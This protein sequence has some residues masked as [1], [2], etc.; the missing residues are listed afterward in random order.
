MKMF[1]KE[2]KLNPPSDANQNNPNNAKQSPLLKKVRQLLTCTLS[3]EIFHKPVYISCGHVFN[4]ISLE[5]ALSNK[6]AC[7]KC[8]KKNVWSTMKEDCNL[9]KISGLVS[10]NIDNETLITELSEYLQ[11]IVLMQLY[12]FPA[13]NKCGHTLEKARIPR[14]GNA[15]APDNVKECPNCRAKINQDSALPNYLMIALVGF[16]LNENPNLVKEQPGDTYLPSSSLLELYIH[17]YQAVI[18]QLALFPHAINKFFKVNGESSPMGVQQFIIK[19][20]QV[21]FLVE[22]LK[23]PLFNNGSEHYVSDGNNSSLLTLAAAES[24]NAMFDYILK[25]PHLDV[26]HKNIRGESALFIAAARGDLIKVKALLTKPQLDLVAKDKLGNTAQQVAR[27]AGHKEIAILLDPLAAQLRGLV[28]KPDFTNIIKILGAAKDNQQELENSINLLLNCLSAE[29]NE[30][31]VFLNKLFDEIVKAK[32]FDANT[33]D[34]IILII[35]KKNNSLVNKPFLPE[36]VPP[37]HYA[38][39]RNDQGLLVCRLIQLQNINVNIA[40]VCVKYNAEMTPLALAVAGNWT[41]H[42]LQILCD[43]GADPNKDMSNTI[44]RA[45]KRKNLEQ[46]KVLL[47]FVKG[48]A[49]YDAWECSKAYGNRDTTQIFE[50]PLVR[51]RIYIQCGNYQQAAQELFNTYVELPQVYEEFTQKILQFL[52]ANISR[53]ELAERLGRALIPLALKRNNKKLCIEYL[54]LAPKLVNEI[55]TEDGKTILHVIIAENDEATLEQLLKMEGLEINKPISN[56]VRF[57]HLSTAVHLACYQGVKV[58]ILEKLLVQH[59]TPHS[60]NAADETPL[61]IATENGDANKVVALLALPDTPDLQR[62]FDIA[63]QNSQDKE[64][65]A[66]FTSNTYKMRMYLQEKNYKKI[67]EL[68]MKNYLSNKQDVTL[69]WQFLSQFLPLNDKSV[70]MHRAIAI[71]L[72]TLAGQT[73]RDILLDVLSKFPELVNKPLVDGKTLL[74][75]VVEKNDI[76]QTTLLLNVEGVESNIQVNRAE[77]PT[78]GFTPLHFACDMKADETQNATEIRSLIVEELLKRNPDVEKTN[79]M[80]ETALYIAARS[81][82][83]SAFIRLLNVPRINIAVRVAGKSLAV[84]ARENDHMSIVILLRYFEITQ[85]LLHKN[86]ITLADLQLPEGI[87]IQ[88]IN[89]YFPALFSNFSQLLAKRTKFILE[90]CSQDAKAS[91]VRINFPASFFLKQNRDANIKQLMEICPASQDLF[92]LQES[93]FLSFEFFLRTILN[94]D[95]KLEC[96]AWAKNH[97]FFCNQFENPKKVAQS[98]PGLFKS[99]MSAFDSDSEIKK[100]LDAMYETIKNQPDSPVVKSAALPKK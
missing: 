4:K 97:I 44:Q 51:L 93:V 95:Q 11:D 53:E 34:K 26:N 30:L 61:I 86:I 65:L 64:F 39:L 72:L 9:A 77:H 31:V 48:Q 68:L 7:P 12:L 94:K 67:A 100:K 5:T 22:L 73:H 89:Q 62:A 69:I 45:I 15:P 23:L 90:Y 3:G 17:G 74:H 54:S 25:L 81:G 88:R 41:T 60:K 98:S 6:D 36:A 35:L 42:V 75:L 85:N 99:I 92:V 2:P 49:L 14:D 43:A 40:A 37:L 58:S 10:K 20:Q 71:E 91:G 52:P 70:L 96:I 38:L 28:Q 46:I 13:I 47:P 50:Q 57:G 80:G 56:P 21:E 66:I 27:D 18:S 16:M 8:S 79:A 32:V 78:N 63:H 55:V 59:A 82:N 24:G 19:K 29:E 33:L 83:V 76:A 84:I 87:E 1:E